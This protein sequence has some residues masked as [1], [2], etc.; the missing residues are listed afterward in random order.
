[1]SK[2]VIKLEGS[3][4]VRVSGLLDSLTASRRAFTL[5]L[6]DGTNVRGRFEE[7]ELERFKELWN[8]QVVI[9]GHADFKPSGTVRH[10]AVDRIGPA[11][12]GDRIFSTQP[13][14]SQ[15]EL[16]PQELRQAQTSGHG[17]GALVGQ[18]PG[19]ETDEE[20]EAELRKLS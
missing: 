6:E 3:E 10:V 5:K 4:R 1:M 17:L 9:I 11:G 18:W 19:E 2:Q 16:T 20:V 12:E 13:T 14:S 15:M 7:D 8:Q